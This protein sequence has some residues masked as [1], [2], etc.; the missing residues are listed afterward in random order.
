MEAF[1][2]V[3]FFFFFCLQHSFDHAED[4]VTVPP[5]FT[6]TQDAAVHEGLK[7]WL[8]EDLA[9]KEQEERLRNIRT[10]A[11]ILGFK[12]IEENK[13]YRDPVELEPEELPECNCKRKGKNCDSNTCQNRAALL[14]CAPERCSERCQNQRFQKRQWIDFSIVKRG[15][16]GYGIITNQDLKQG[17]FVMEV[18]VVVA[19]GPPR[20]F[21]TCLSTF[22]GHAVCW[23]GH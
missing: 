4:D 6:P 13:M 9:A 17:D 19:G 10:R 18:S 7:A 23:R 11:Q 1:F 5:M 21:R 14:E 3:F 2:S 15:R 22:G 16:M 20:L 8:S 12:Y